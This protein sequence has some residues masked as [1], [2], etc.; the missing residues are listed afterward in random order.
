MAAALRIGTAGWAIP[1]AVASRFPEGGSG[2]ARYAARLDAAEINS[3]FYRSHRPGTWARWRDTTAAGFSFAVK[4][5][6]AVTHEAR[7]ADVRG[8]LAEFLEEARLL[9]DRLGPILV[10]LPPSLAY[11][12]NVAERFFA[13]LR[14]LHEASVAVEPRHPSWFEAAPQALLATWRVARVAADPAPHP[15]AAD[16]GGWPGLAY[17]RLHGSPRMYYSPYDDAF[18][19][20]LAARLAASEAAETWCVFD[21][22]TSGAAAA[23]ALDLQE[24]VAPLAPA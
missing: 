7:L 21:N 5:P 18:L 22:T 2:L 4:A 17:W 23:N 14:D 24:L 9:G 8:R 13:D 12:A 1:R 11:D 10:Q 20:R 6:K 15:A 3:S 16:P 19:Q